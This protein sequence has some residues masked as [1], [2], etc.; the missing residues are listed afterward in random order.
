[1]ILKI[2]AQKSPDSKLR[3]KRYADLKFRGQK[4]EF[5]SMWGLIWKMAGA[6][7]NWNCNLEQMDDINYKIGG[8]GVELQIEFESQGPK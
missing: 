1:V 6:L 5:G 4:Y 8:L 3:L 7:V 2:L